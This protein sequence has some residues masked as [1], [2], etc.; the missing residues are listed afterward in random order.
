MPSFVYHWGQ[1]FF[2]NNCCLI[3]GTFTTT[4]QTSSLYLFCKDKGRLTP[5]Q[6]HIT[7]ECI[8]LGLELE[9]R[10]SRISL[11]FFQK[12]KY[13]LLMMSPFNTFGS[14]N[15]ILFLLLVEVS[16]L[17]ITFFFIEL[18]I[19]SVLG[20]AEW[21]LFYLKKIFPIPTPPLHSKG[22][23]VRGGG[24]GH[25]LCSN[26]WVFFNSQKQQSEGQKWASRRKGRQI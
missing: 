11:F 22:K 19:L 6:F 5:F 17:Y 8:K 18:A 4:S 2:E 25:K 23:A 9:F 1:T 3:Y 16:D 24:G 26:R 12:M 13:I 10:I 14:I 20:I 15:L 7:L 21:R